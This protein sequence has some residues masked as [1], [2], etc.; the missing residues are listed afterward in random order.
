[1]TMIDEAIREK[2]NDTKQRK[3]IERWGWGWGLGFCFLLFLFFL[4]RSAHPI[5]QEE[6]EEEEKAAH[7]PWL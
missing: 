1:M 4:D 7:S 6:E 3:R 2:G 5:H